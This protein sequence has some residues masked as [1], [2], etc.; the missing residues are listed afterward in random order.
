[1][2]RVRPAPLIAAVLACGLVSCGRKEQS[3]APS[4]AVPAAASAA[5][6]RTSALLVLLP[7]NDEVPGW[8]PDGTPK[9]ASAAT[10]WELINGAAENYLAF[11]FREAVSARFRSGERELVADVF[12]MK[13]AVNAFGIFAQERVMEG[14]TIPVGVEGVLAGSALSFWAGPHYVKI[15]AFDEQPATQEAMQR[16]A[17]SIAAKI[18]EAGEA[19]PQLSWFPPEH[20]LPHGIGYIPKDVLGQS[21][22]SNAFEAKYRS[23]RA[24]YRLLVVG[25]ETAEAATQALATY[26][27]FLSG[28]GK[29]A[30]DLSVPGTDG[31]FEGEDGF[32]GPVLAVRAGRYL[33]LALGAPS[34]AVGRTALEQLARRIGQDTAVP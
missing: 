28:T 22:L 17:A 3:P 26:R 34:P 32:N 29:P 9:T 25:P 6:A 7:T 31:G 15:T 2:A 12:T 16:L 11:G 13:D 19:P 20:L 1:M 27:R 10:L 33:L 23:G 24:E 8:R 5:P 21:S 14:R 4:D 18:G 30:T